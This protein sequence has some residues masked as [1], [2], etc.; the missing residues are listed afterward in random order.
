MRI[1]V[2][3][4]GGVGGY[5][6]G[7]L[8]RAYASTGEH[9]LIFI[10]RGEHLKAI[11][12][13]GLR[14]FTCEGDYT[15][16]PNIATDHPDRLG[17]LDLI[18]FCVKS[19]A[20][21]ESAE[22][23]KDHVCERTVAIPLLNGVN[24][25]QRIKSVLPSADIVG[26]SVYIISHIEKPGVIRQVDGACRLTFGTDDARK[27]SRYGFILDLLLKAGIDAVLTDRISEVLW[28]KY[29]L[30][31]PLGSLTAATGKTYGEILADGKL[32]AILQE[33]MEEVA[34]VA[35]AKNIR[36]KDDAVEKTLSLVGTFAYNAKTSMQIDRERG[37]PTEIDALT[38]HIRQAGSEAGIATPRHD[39]I[40]RMLTV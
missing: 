10:A 25:A 5:F 15:A 8:A 35:R 6:G 27:S 14:L 18:L 38:A 4:I 23:F 39:E 11:Q 26:G 20:L 32:K 28:T 21:E 29:L 17:I 7:K 36:L 24:S 12:Q 3:G 1:A 16:W 22:L 37:K 40:Y 19:Y 2:V 33:M 31:C 34:A 9:E 13:N 30:M